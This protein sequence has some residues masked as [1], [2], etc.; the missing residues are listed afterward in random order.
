MLFCTHAGQLRIRAER[1]SPCLPPSA[2]GA[3]GPA[4][5]W[6]CRAEPGH[7]QESPG[8]GQGCAA[9][10]CIPAGEPPYLRAC[11][12]PA[13]CSQENCCEDC[14]CICVLS[15]RTVCTETSPHLPLQRKG[16]RH[17]NVVQEYAGRRC[18]EQEA[19]YNTGRA[20]HQLG[21]LHVAVPLYERALAA[22]APAA[23]STTDVRREAAHNLV[24]IYRS[25]GA[26]ELARQIMHEYLAF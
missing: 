9:G 25:T 16:L 12:R 23:S 10:L 11:E 2:T 21:L 13:C 24:L 5:H 26:I 20:A 1:V 18:N 6:N 15:C 8:Q 7:A 14:K 22:P 19:L 3:P 17:V 4:V